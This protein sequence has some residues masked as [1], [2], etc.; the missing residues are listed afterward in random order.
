M[1]DIVLAVN[2]RP[3]TMV[4][5]MKCMEAQFNVNITFSVETEPLG[6]AGPLALARHVLD[7]DSEPFFV[8]N[9]DVICDFPFERMIQ[10]HKAHGK[11]GTILVTKVEEPS[12]YGVI[13]TMPDSNQIDRFV[14]KPREYVSNRINAGI[15]L[16]L[17]SMLNRI[18]PRPTSIEKEIFPSM[19]QQGALFSMD[20]DGFWMDIGQPKDFL[21]G[22]GLYLAYL[23]YICP[24]QLELQSKINSIINEPVMIHPTAIIGSDCKIGPNVV[25]G[26]GVHI[27]DGVRLS[28]CVI[29][30][31]ATLGN[32]V[33]IT[34]SI[35]G[36][37]CR[38]GNWTRLEGVSVLGEDVQVNDEVYVNG[39]LVLPHKS[40]TTSIVSPEIIM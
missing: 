7:K 3:E 11:E 39:G 35:I 2:Y 22:T 18:E 33:W 5:H 15:Y 16:F 28:K 34:S 37:R 25:I 32:Y 10:F 26:P 14:E 13:V 40:I 12:K 8:L 1:Q 20:L 9:S 31:A 36:W 17:P 30:E 24:A 21:H 29:M 6:T 27:G 19:A 38:I 23:Q 4:E